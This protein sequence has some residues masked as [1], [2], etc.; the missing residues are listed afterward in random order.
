ME[1]AFS[2]MNFFMFLTHDCQHRHQQISQLQRRILTYRLVKL[3]N[4][5]CR[6]GFRIFSF[7]PLFFVFC[8][9]CDV[10]KTQKPKTL[11]NFLE[12][13][14]HLGASSLVTGEKVKVRPNHFMVLR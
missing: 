5:V 1:I 6:N 13:L 8:F 2:F 14:T 10:S 3:A 4:Q 11:P 9:L 7:G 12:T